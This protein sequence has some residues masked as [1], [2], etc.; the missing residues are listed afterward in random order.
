MASDWLRV[1]NRLT[2]FSVPADTSVGVQRCIAICEEIPHLMLKVLV[3]RAVNVSVRRWVQGATE[4]CGPLRSTVTHC[5]LQKFPKLSYNMHMRYCS[6]CVDIAIVRCRGVWR[7]TCP[8]LI[9]RRKM[10][11]QNHDLPPAATS[12]DHLPDLRG[13]PGLSENLRKRDGSHTSMLEKLLGQSF[14]RRSSPVRCVSLNPTILTSEL[15]SLDNTDSS[16]DEHA[17]C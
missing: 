11:L 1:S 16:S 15:S 5:N 13:A 7:Y 14:Q 6:A 10:Q 9:H 3:L 17:F 4:C 2:S 8:A 12:H